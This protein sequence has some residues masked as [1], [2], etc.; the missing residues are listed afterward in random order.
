[1]LGAIIGANPQAGSFGCRLYFCVLGIE[2]II[3]YQLSSFSSDFLSKY[4]ATF[5][6]RLKIL[7]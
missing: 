5:D 2:F 1:V 7:P 4:K 6:V 3:S